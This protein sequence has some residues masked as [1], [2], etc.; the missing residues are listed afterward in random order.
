MIGL[1]LFLVSVPL[2]IAGLCDPKPTRSSVFLI[3]AALAAPTGL[4]AAAM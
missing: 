4:L 3:A 1:S 2:G